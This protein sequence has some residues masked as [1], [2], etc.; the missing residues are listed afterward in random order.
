M[1]TDA[2]LFDLIAQAWAAYDRGDRRTARGL[3]EQ[4]RAYAPR[5]PDPIAAL[6]WF[7]LDADQPEAAAALLKPALKAHPEAWALWWY[8]G[9][10]YQRQGDLLAA[11]GALRRACCGDPALDSA[12]FTLAW[13]LH[14][15]GHL[16]EAAAWSRYAV[17]KSHAPER[18]QQAAWLALRTGAPQVAVD[19]Y[20][21]L[22]EC[23]P[24]DAPDW[25]V[26]RRHFASALEQAGDPEQALAVLEAAGADDPA[27]LAAQAWL[28]LR[29]DT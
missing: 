14:D 29:L 9:L 5:A 28:L 25:A 1:R 15:L 26:L 18:L 8:L 20:R 21:A 24:S 3:A 11:A 7:H 6:A 4:A 10:V 22:F 16:D 2:A 23:L 17:G 19:L 27:G 13:V 12:A